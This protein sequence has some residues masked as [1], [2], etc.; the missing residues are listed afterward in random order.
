MDDTLKIEPAEWFKEMMFYSKMYSLIRD[1]KDGDKEAI[2]FFG[3]CGDPKRSYTAARKELDRWFKDENGY[4]RI[5]KLI[6][7]L[8]NE[9]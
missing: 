2:R 6:D 1:Y 9:E 4:E 7:T 5:R 3:R 8:G